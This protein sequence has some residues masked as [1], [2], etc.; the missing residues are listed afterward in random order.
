V[1]TRRRQVAAWRRWTA[2]RPHNRVRRAVVRD[3]SGRK[4]GYGEAVPVPEPPLPAVG[5][6]TVTRPSGRVEVELAGPSG[7]ALRRLQE[8]YRL[9]RHPKPTAAEVQPLPVTTAE[10]RDWLAAVSGA[11]G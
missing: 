3:A 2:K 11:A 10:V 1:L 5:C 6:R 7:E 4:V 8:A 9:A